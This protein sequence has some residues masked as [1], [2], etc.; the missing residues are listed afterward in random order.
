MPVNL[1]AVN[2]IMDRY[3]GQEALLISILQDVQDSVPLAMI[4]K[5]FHNTLVEIMVEVAH[6]IAERQVVLTGGCFQ[7]R[8]LV[9]RTV[10]RLRA[11]GF[12][13]Y[14]HQRIPPNDGGIALGQ[15]VATSRLLTSR[16]K[17][18]KEQRDR[19]VEG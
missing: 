15:V 19:G 1:D 8:V 17:G 9:E 18:E 4:S 13:P 2:V 7:N 11:E 10:Q 14:W 6:R 3:K 16:G 5:K 12:K